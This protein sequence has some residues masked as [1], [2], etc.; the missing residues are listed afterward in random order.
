M[1]FFDRETAGNLGKLFLA[2][3]AILG[4]AFALAMCSHS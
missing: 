3:A 1:S 2:F 4:V